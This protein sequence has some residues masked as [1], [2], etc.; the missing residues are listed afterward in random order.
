MSA[1]DTNT[2]KEARRHRVPLW[3]F[4]GVLTWAL[5]LLAGLL[6]WTAYQSGNPTATSPAEIVTE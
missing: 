2:E 4:A 5:V 3:G 1:P 6:I